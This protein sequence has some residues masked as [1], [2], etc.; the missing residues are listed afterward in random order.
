ME[1]FELYPRVLSKRDG[2]DDMGAVGKDCGDSAWARRESAASLLAAR[3]QLAQRLQERRAPDGDAADGAAAA[4]EA[5]DGHGAKGG[6]RRGDGGGMVATRDERGAAGR[7]RAAAE[8]P[9]E[10]GDRPAAGG[11]GC[12]GGRGIDGAAGSRACAAA[13][14]GAPPCP[15]AAGA[16]PTRPQKGRQD[17]PRPRVAIVLSEEERARRRR[18]V[19]IQPK[20]SRLSFPFSPRGKDQECAQQDMEHRSRGGIAFTI[21]DDAGCSPIG[22]A[23]GAPTLGGAPRV[24][25]GDARGAPRVDRAGCSPMG[26]ALRR[27]AANEAALRPARNLPPRR[28]KTLIAADEK[29]GGEHSTPNRGGARSRL[30]LRGGGG[31]TV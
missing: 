5:L 1:V 13:L 11:R 29:D 2:A 31:L 4:R 22:D 26:D 17:R 7:I 8:D 27:P 3:V 16:N 30:A 25:M 24:L 15:A 18:L 23:R 14:A 21:G 20:I 6:R 9:R 28:A 10:R 19:E 12:D